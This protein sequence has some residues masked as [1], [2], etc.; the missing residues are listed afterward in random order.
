MVSDEAI[1]LGQGFDRPIGVG[2]AGP[3]MGGVVIAI[4]GRMSPV[5][6]VDP[7]V[8]IVEPRLKVSGRP[9]LR[10][11]AEHAVVLQATIGMR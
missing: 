11:C 7:A 6:Y 10:T 4:L 8:V 9:D 1:A 3:D 2:R 5:L